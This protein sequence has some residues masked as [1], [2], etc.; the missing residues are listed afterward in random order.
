MVKRTQPSMAE[1][2]LGA[3]RQFT[4][5]GTIV[6][7]VSD[8]R[9][10]YAKTNP[11][12]AD[13]SLAMLVDGTV[14]DGSSYERLRT[15]TP[16]KGHRTWGNTAANR[17]YVF[18]TDNSDRRWVRVDASTGAR[19]VIHTY[20]AS[21]VGLSS[22]STVDYGSYEGNMDN[23]DTGAVLIA[24]GVRPFLISPATGAVRCTVRSGGG[25]SR[26][27]SDATMSQDGRY[28][29]VNWVGYG[30]D[31]YRA[32]D[33]GFHRRLTPN[34]GHYDACVSA[35][36]DQV[37]V[38]LSN[39]DMVRISDGAVTGVFNADS[40]VRGHVSC[41]NTQRPGWAYFS[42]YNDN[43]DSYQQAMSSF[44]R[45]MAVKLDGSQKVEYFAWD[46]EACPSTYDQNPMAV[47]S[48]TGERVW[49]KVNWNG[50]SSGI[51]SF[52][53]ER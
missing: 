49:W 2:P 36:G 42:I 12:N 10:H 4:D 35:A 18:G 23:A 39:A 32:S 44:H 19:A 3:T 8:G 15:I 16:P 47:P 7:R 30:V 25:Y 45:I 17:N 38:Q 37:I 20:A 29:L 31:A 21:E 22:L 27:V 5:L 51:H 26:S 48:R 28:I 9:H 11:W 40:S 41:R 24:N 34:T 14:L 6:T 53:A 13:E 50:S 43:C 46:H 33:C 1:P 52:V